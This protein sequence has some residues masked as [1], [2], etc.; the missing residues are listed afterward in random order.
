MHY[1]SNDL[2]VWGGGDGILNRGNEYRI[3][4]V[5][6]GRQGQEFTLRY[7]SGG[8]I[9]KPVIW[10]KAGE[11]FKHGRLKGGTHG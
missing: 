9:G 10:W 2:V 3:D 1:K 8:A 7:T 11:P 4:K 5:R 6:T